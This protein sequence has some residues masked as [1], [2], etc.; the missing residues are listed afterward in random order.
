MYYYT[1]HVAQQ[2]TQSLPILDPILKLERT[3]SLPVKNNNSYCAVFETICNQPILLSIFPTTLCT[4]VRHNTYCPVVKFLYQTT[5]FDTV[6]N[7]KYQ[8]HII[9]IL[10]IHYVIF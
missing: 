9:Y 8:R 10:F 7:I 6:E 5:T 1:I 3:S 4:M 2:R